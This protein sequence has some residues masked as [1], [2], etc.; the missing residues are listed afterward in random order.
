MKYVLALSVI[1]IA[2]GAGVWYF[3]ENEKARQA[4]LARQKELD[5]I[6]EEERLEKQRAEDE[7]IRK[8]RME[9]LAKDDAVL[10]LQ[11]YVSRQEAQLKT[12][13]EECRIKR[14]VIALD[15]QS[16]S[17]ELVALEKEEERKAADAKRRNIKRREQNERVDALLSSPV[18]NRLALTYMGED[19][20]A[21][22]ARFRSHV[23]NVIKLHEEG[24]ARLAANKKKLTDAIAAADKETDRLILQTHEEG[25]RT[26][27]SIQARIGAMRNRVDDLRSKVEKLKKKSRSVKLS[28]WEER[29]LDRWT[30]D[31]EVAEAQLASDENSLGLGGVSLMHV[32]ATMAETKARRTADTAL[33]EKEDEDVAVLKDISFEGDVFVLATGYEERS[34][35]MIRAAL[36]QAG[37][38]LDGQIGQIES[39]LKYL[40][41]VPA[42][43]DFLSS[44][45]VEELRKK[46]SRRLVDDF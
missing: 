46:V 23:G 45:E 22:R 6:R 35:G 3:N 37:D 28:Q 33:N 36:K 16:L 4:E 21:A 25:K 14:Q 20:S 9:A 30:R 40:S 2:C 32:K 26:Y 18:L 41:E 27:G 13:L 10:L 34:L 31:L 39:K 38:A 19:L 12:E 11:K 7:R 44:A 8:E 24:N 17:D 15:Q 43:M 5:R 29:D 1:L 42:N